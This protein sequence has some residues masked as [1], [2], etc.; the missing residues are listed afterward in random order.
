MYIVRIEIL[1]AHGLCDKT[2]QEIFRSLVVARLSYA[3]PAW[4]GFAGSR[5]RQIIDEFLRPC[6]GTDVYSTNLPTFVNYVPRRTVI[7]SIKYSDI[8]PCFA[9]LVPSCFIHFTDIF[10]QTSSTW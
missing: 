10:T 1:R 6:T 5:D 8:L 2:I 9:P 3:F 7:C 4:R